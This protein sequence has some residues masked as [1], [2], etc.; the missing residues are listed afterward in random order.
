MSI[1]IDQPTYLVMKDP[2]DDKGFKEWHFE[3]KL[4]IHSH[5][6]WSKAPPYYLQI[7]TIGRHHPTAVSPEQNTFVRSYF[8]S[9]DPNEAHVKENWYGSWCSKDKASFIAFFEHL[10]QEHGAHVTVY[11]AA[12]NHI[13][14]NGYKPLFDG[15]FRGW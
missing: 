9:H 13:N 4:F 6:M 7:P 8:K 12:Y 5:K 3:S 1:T 15:G 10:I 2:S 11:D 14:A